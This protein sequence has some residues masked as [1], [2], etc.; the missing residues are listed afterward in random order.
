MKI[1]SDW[2]IKPPRHRAIDTSSDREVQKSRNGQIERFERDRKRSSWAHAE[3]ERTCFCD[4]N[5]FHV[6]LSFVLSLPQDPV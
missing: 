4:N 1:L 6:H 2:V 5:V 3:V